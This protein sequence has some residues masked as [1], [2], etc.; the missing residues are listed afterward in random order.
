V[1]VMVGAAGDDG[2]REVSIYSRG[3]DAGEWTR[4]ATGMLAAQATQPEAG[5]QQWPPAG[6]VPV[7][8]AGFYPGL[9][10]AGYQYG[11]AFRGLRAAWRREEE[12][13]AEVA[14]PE[15][16]APGGFAVH[17]ALLDAALHALIAGQDGQV[18]IPFA[19]TGL[20]VHA[21]GPSAAR[22]RIAAAG[23][24]AVSVTL[25]DAA[26]QPVASVD[27]LVLR[28]LPASATAAEALFQVAWTP[29]RTDGQE[30]ERRPPGPVAVLGDDAGLGVTD[31]V[32]YPDLT[33][34]A[35]AAQAAD[36]PAAGLAVY[37]ARPGEGNPAVAGR[38]L[39]G[40]V[41]GLAQQWLGEPALATW[42]LAIVTE[43]AVDAGPEAE[44]DPAAA[45]VWGLV[46]AAAAENPGRLILGDTDDL[47]GAGELV[48][49]GAALGEP[50]FAVRD[51]QL[52]VPRLTRA[53]V[54]A[55]T[56]RL[57]AG[58]T[59]ITGASGGL[60]QLVAR[61]LAATGTQQ[62][63]LASRRGPS[64]PGTAA[65]AA[66]L[67]ADGAGV[68]VTACDAADRYQLAQMITRVPVGAPLRGV[69]HAA[70]VL[71]DGVTGSLT[72]ARVDA[73]MRPKADAAWHLH[74]LTADHDLDAFVLFSS[75][76]GIVGSPGQG[77]YAA[78]NTFLDALAAHRV[79]R[80]LP[81]LSLAWGPW[82]QGMAGRL[83][84]AD[85][86]RLAAQGLR[87]L[88]DAEGLALLDAAAGAGQPALVPVRLDPAALRGRGEGLPPLLS[89][90]ATR[91][92]AAAPPA[93]G[94]GSGSVTARL[95]A[96]PPDEQQAA[97]RQIIRAEAAAVLGMS[98][99]GD[100]DAGRSFREL[101]FDSLA[102][103]DLRNRLATVTGLQLPATMAFDY[104]TLDALTNY[105]L[106]RIVDRSADDLPVLQELDK[107][108][109]AL[110]ALAGSSGGRSR[111]M[112]RLEAIVEDFRTGTTDNASDYHEISESTDDEIFDLIDK[113]L[114][115]SD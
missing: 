62:L 81:A 25:A 1:Q 35:D 86:R 26:G 60:G 94:S 87:A 99:L 37:C 27:Q 14:L 57:R 3:A 45:P 36:L 63:L 30:A 38:E 55:A 50:E 43:R 41:L 2:R 23:P 97:A 67:A 31:A 22:V 12:L 13:F 10:E 32:R 100:D 48:I 85:R 24:E 39:A 42:R 64:A 54:P 16:T 19:F 66:Q 84:A 5:W 108:E 106:G 56:G 9:A 115:L 44:V 7:N 89:G 78:A 73:V 71:D 92:H 20:A 109:S 61:H 49:A 102:A 74:E 70:G 11:P 96:L 58:S 51:G 6:A 114:G 112:T 68:Q 93:A 29:A 77:N 105:I 53:T 17:P 8:L 80:G 110:S 72:P 47:A 34:L 91:R 46:R 52:R 76:A 4:H 18:K 33:A 65:L 28:A 103:V 59:L 104:P 98:A 107:L 95:A 79:R 83:S 82:E 88:A 15:G 113:E 111:I 21:A 69:I 101:G 90:L 40:Q 75:A